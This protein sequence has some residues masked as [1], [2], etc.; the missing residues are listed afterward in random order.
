MFP[1]HFW[2]T[3]TGAL[4]GGL[5]AL[6]AAF[7]GS[8]AWA[9]VALTLGARLLMSPLSIAAARRQDRQRQRLAALKPRLDALKQRHAG[10]AAALSAATMALYREEGV[11]FLDRLVLANVAAQAAF[12]IGFWQA[13]RQARPAGGFLWV[14]SLSRPDAWLALL[15]GALMLLALSA[16]PAAPEATQAGVAQAMVAVSV[17]IAV[18]TL[19]SMPS[20]MG[21]YWAASNV[22]TLAQALVLR[23]LRARDTRAAAQTRSTTSAMP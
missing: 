9:I 4:A 12:G 13:L 10:D 23:G 15:V 3:W 22:A 11:S 21:V 7:G 1:W 8:E 18:A 19:W 6:A 14:P 5:H 20:A 16:A 2:T 17:V